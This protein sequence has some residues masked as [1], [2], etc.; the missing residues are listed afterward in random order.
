[1]WCHNPSENMTIQRG[2]SK[3]LVLSPSCIPRFFQ[4][5]SLTPPE[6]I[7]HGSKRHN[8]S[9]VHTCCDLSMD[10]IGQ[11]A[12]NDEVHKEILKN[13]R[14]KLNITWYRALEKNIQK[15]YP[16]W[17]SKLGYNI[18]TQRGE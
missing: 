16:G 7:I 1:M 9:V 6:F 18:Y 12:F 8:Q 2:N 3:T 5:F 14:A 17:T 4:M 15:W 13:S 11:I 10:E